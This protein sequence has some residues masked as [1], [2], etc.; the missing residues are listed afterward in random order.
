MRSRGILPPPLHCCPVSDSASPDRQCRERDRRGGGG[1]DDADVGIEG[2]CDFA[3]CDHGGLGADA[4]VE[5]AADVD[6]A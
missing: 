1:G 6:V 3:E 5:A 2:A 4:D